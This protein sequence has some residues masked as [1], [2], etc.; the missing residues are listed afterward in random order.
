MKISALGVEEQRVNIVVD[1]NDP[2]ET[3]PGLADGYRVEVRVVLWEGDEVRQVP[4]G[5]LFRDG[6]GWRVFAVEKGR[7]RLRQVEIGRQ[8]GL[9]AEVLSGLEEGDRVILHPGDSIAEG[10]R[11]EERR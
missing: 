1:F 3:R 5:S 2:P 11:V 8:G 9:V 6:E 10:L 7:A 4:T